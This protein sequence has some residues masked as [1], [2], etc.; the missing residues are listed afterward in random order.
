MRKILLGLFLLFGC[1]A[2]AQSPIKDMKTYAGKP[3]FAFF[4]QLIIK[5]NGN[6][7]FNF[8]LNNDKV[9]VELLVPN[10]NNNYD[11]VY[12]ELQST[13]TT[14]GYRLTGFKKEHFAEWK[15][16]TLTKTDKKFQDKYEIWNMLIIMNDGTVSKNFQ[17][18]Q[19]PYQPPVV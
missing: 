15:T 4:K 5:N 3:S 10:S 13:K 14:T 12:P 8:I 9:I 6:A 19:I 17:M 7:P 18:I 1:S 2:L 11:V 16:V